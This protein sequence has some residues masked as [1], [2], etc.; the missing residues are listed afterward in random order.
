MSGRPQRLRWLIVRAGVH[1]LALLVALGPEPLFAQTQAAMQHDLPASSSVAVTHYLPPHQVQAHIVQPDDFTPPWDE[2]DRLNLWQHGL[3]TPEAVTLPINV[4]MLPTGARVRLAPAAS[5]TGWTSLMTTQWSLTSHPACRRLPTLTGVRSQVE[6]SLRSELSQPSPLSAPVIGEYRRRWVCIFANPGQATNFL[7]QFSLHL[8]TRA[9]AETLFV[10]VS[11]DGRTFWGRRWRTP[12]L[13]TPAT[14]W[15]MQRIYFPTDPASSTA[16]VA[17]LWEVQQPTQ[18]R[19]PAGI[20]LANFSVEA[21]IPPPASCG[22]LDPVL[23]LPASG[24][25]QVSK[26]LN[27]PPYPDLTPSGLA[28]HVARLRALGV[29]WVRVELQGRAGSAPAGLMLT[30]RGGMLGYVDLKHYDTLF[31]LLCRSESPI[32]VLGLLDN[33]LMPTDGWRNRQAAATYRQAYTTLT[34]L[35]ARYY[36]DRVHA[37]ELWNEPDHVNT[38]LPPGDFAALLVEAG[39]AIRRSVPAARIVT[40]GVSSVGPAAVAYLRQT[41]AALTG[42]VAPGAGFDVVGVHLYPDVEYCSGARPVREPTFLYDDEP[43]ILVRLMR[44]LAAAGYA[45]RPL[46]VT[47]IGWNRAADSDN[48][49]T[50]ACACVAATLV[51]GSEQAAY[52]PQAFD[53]L[54]R[55]SAWPSTAPGVTKVFWYQYADV[56]LSAAAAGCGDVG[57]VVDWWYGLYS[58]IDSAA[59]I[60]EPQPNRAAC[61]FRAWP[62]AAAVAACLG[63]PE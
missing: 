61:T 20:H 31:E 28:G 41:L 30:G 49:A 56:G 11:T 19:Q 24:S 15:Q 63:Q 42:L 25:N 18:V 35:L 3:P 50:H 22:Q 8:E 57:G 40:G 10:C 23:A 47:E 62:D 45:D 60:L 59:G 34:A 5:S 58:G 53:I 1:L 9:F 43:T 48:P 12:A 33:M 55:E 2:A 17:V 16:G 14:P 39:A 29:Q 37:W 44:V 7:L 4:L 32:A 6:A 52:L 38:Y 51:N 26:G 21:F 54:V 46:W 13:A 27:L 36:A